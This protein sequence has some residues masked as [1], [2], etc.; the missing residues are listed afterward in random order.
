MARAG[1]ATMQNAQAI[2][3]AGSD[4]AGLKR[5]ASEL[6]EEIMPG[7]DAFGLEVID[8]DAE[9]VEMAVECLGATIGALLTIPFMGGKKLVWLK[10]VSLFSDTVIGRSETVIEAAAKLCDVLE[11]GLPEGIIFLAS[12]VSPDKRRS[13]YKRLEKICHREIIDLPEMGG[14]GNNE[15]KIIRWVETQTQEKGMQISYEA[16]KILAARVGLNP[17]QLSTELEK[18]ST[19]FGRQAEVNAQ[20]VR[21]LVPQTREG[22]IFD[23]NEAIL[24]RDLPL[25]LDTLAQFFV[26]GEKSVG[27][28]LASIVPTVRNLLLVKDLMVRHKISTPAHAGRFAD[29]LSRLPAGETSHLPRKKDGSGINAYPL[30][31]AGMAASRFTLA[32]LQKGFAA[33]AET[34]SAILGTTDDRVILERLIFLLLSK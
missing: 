3:V 23:L 1:N 20:G 15:E 27:I 16:V 13:A 4:E 34:V 14:F 25:A 19:A 18:L 32:E 26:Q 10:N 33:C 21:L 7:A 28:L 6:S 17:M 9:N 12:I 31:L 11:A 30:G 2:L 5:R 29:L 22:G 8:G 24:L